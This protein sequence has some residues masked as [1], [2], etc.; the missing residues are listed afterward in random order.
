M[1]AAENV[2]KNKVSLFKEDGYWGVR[3]NG[4]EAIPA[5]HKSPEVAVDEWACFERMNTMEN[6][7]LD[8]RLTLREI[9][10]ITIELISGIYTSK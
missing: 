8:H 7:F 4:C 5:V 3:H 1:E 6:Q 10:E 9:T 2:Q